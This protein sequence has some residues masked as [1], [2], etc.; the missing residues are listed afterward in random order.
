LKN[1]FLK[2]SSEVFSKGH[3]KTED[4]FEKERNELDAKIGELEMQRNWLKKKSK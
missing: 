2:H 1:E 4:A 3:S